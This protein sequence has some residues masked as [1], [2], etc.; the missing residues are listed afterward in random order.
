M[1]SYDKPLHADTNLN[2]DWWASKHITICWHDRPVFQV[3]HNAI[4]DGSGRFD[5]YLVHDHGKA[6]VCVRTVAEAE[7]AIVLFVD[8]FCK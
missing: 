5:G 6:M 3:H 4:R 1:R 8:R 2:D 7:A